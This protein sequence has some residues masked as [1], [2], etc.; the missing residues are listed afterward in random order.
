M[1][2]KLIGASKRLFVRRTDTLNSEFFPSQ[3]VYSAEVK[4]RFSH[5]MISI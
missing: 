3:A 5:L 2:S 1:M 4:R